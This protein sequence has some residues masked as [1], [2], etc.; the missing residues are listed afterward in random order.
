MTEATGTYRLI[1]MGSSPYS[2]KVRAVLRYRRIPHLWIYRSQ[3]VRAE[4][5]HLRPPLIPVL[6]DPEGGYHVDSTPMIEELERRHPRR[7]VWPAMPGQAFLCRLLEDM[8]DEWLTKAMFHLRWQAEPDRGFAAGWIV[9]DAL[10]AADGA[11]RRA[12]ADAIRDR[13]VTRTPLVGCTPENDAVIR[14]SLER[15][16]DAMEGRVT[17]GAWLFG[18][19]PSVADFAIYGQLGPMVVDPTPQALIRA[20]APRLDS[21]VRHMDDLSGEPDG[22][23]DEAGAPLRPALREL[24]ALA[25][26]TYLPFLAANAAALAAGRDEVALAIGGRRFAQAPFGY[27]AK[28]LSHLRAAWAALPVAAAAELRPVLAETG[29]LPVLEG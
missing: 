8:A 29:C 16:L 14:A 2:L 21:W 11:E 7:G 10:P 4:I 23:W 17:R 20:R 24:L 12:A 9:D 3:E 13:Q 26:D 15:W 27:Q 28:C 22:E 5:A 19:R 18:S 1:G 25:G 6:Q